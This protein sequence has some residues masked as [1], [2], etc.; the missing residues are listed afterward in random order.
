MQYLIWYNTER[1]HRSIGCIP[2]LRYYLDRFFTCPQQSNMLWTLT[3]AC[4][5]ACFLLHWIRHMGL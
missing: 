3:P 1:P 2:P 4:H 5:Y